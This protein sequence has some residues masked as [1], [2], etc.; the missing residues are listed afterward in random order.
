MIL[1]KIKKLID[2]CNQ[3]ECFSIAV[4]GGI[5]SM[6][7]AYIANRFSDAKVKTV[8][9]FSPA[10]PETAFERVKEHAQRHQWDLFIIFQEVF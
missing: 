6:L 9:A 10:V 2:Y 5:D 7:L 3:F 4:S 1:V 8:H